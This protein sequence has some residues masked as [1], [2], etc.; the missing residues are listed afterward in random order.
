M[1]SKYHQISLNYEIKLTF[2]VVCYCTNSWNIIC[3]G[4][5]SIK[6]CKPALASTCQ[7]LLCSK[8]FCIERSRV[9][10]YRNYFECLIQLLD[11]FFLDSHNN[12]KPFA[13]SKVSYKVAVPNSQLDVLRQ[14]PKGTW[15]NTNIVK[16]CLQVQTQTKSKVKL[17]A[18]SSPTRSYCKQLVMRFHSVNV[19]S[20]HKTCHKYA[21]VNQNIFGCSYLVN[22]KPHGYA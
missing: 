15:H 19:L 1:S 13:N 4:L 16:T 3:F 14:A 18:T 21:C 12:L 9:V 7:W 5:F 11:R 8:L 10:F 17:N 6:Y 20:A 22:P 2:N